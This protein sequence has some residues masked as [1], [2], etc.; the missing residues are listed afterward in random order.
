[1]HKQLKKLLEQV[2]GKS[3]SIISIFCDIW[4]FTPFCYKIESYQVGLYLQKLY[5]KILNEYFPDATFFKTTGDG[6]LVVISVDKFDEEQCKKKITDVI[7]TCLILLEDFNTFFKKDVLINFETPINIGFGLA[8]GSACCLRAEDK[9]IDYSG[10]VL[11]LSQR[12]LDFARPK[13]IVTDTSFGLQFLPEDLKKLFS[14]DRVFIKGIAEE[15]PFEIHYTNEYTKI[16]K[17]DKNPIKDIEWEVKKI[18]KK[19]KIIKKLDAARVTLPSKPL[20]VKQIQVRMDCPFIVNSGKIDTS[21]TRTTAV[22]DFYFEYVSGEPS[23][24]INLKKINPLLKKWNLTDEMDVEFVI[25][26]QKIYIYIYIKNGSFYCL[27]L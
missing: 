21:V 9:I 23:V 11:N 1:M 8:R 17:R 7:E 24:W 20:D 13:G 14:Q 26:F 22:S 18:R 10:R 16:S 6:L 4:G 5:L 27:L 12:L 3:E 25:S 15:E 19:I 2:E